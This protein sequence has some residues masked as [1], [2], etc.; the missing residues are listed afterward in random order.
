MLLREGYIMKTCRAAAFWY[1]LLIKQS[2]Y[3]PILDVSSCSGNDS[4]PTVNTLDRF[5]PSTPCGPHVE[6]RC[7]QKTH[8]SITKEAWQ[9]VTLWK[10]TLH[11]WIC[12]NWY[13]R[14]INTRIYL[15]LYPSAQPV[16]CMT[17]PPHMNVY[18][19]GQTKTWGWC[20]VSVTLLRK[21]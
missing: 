9:F 14:L 20:S 13:Y 17:F 4:S 1:S 5:L 16:T 6:C 10:V 8:I 12:V 19:S 15:V 18:I 3:R 2:V 11:H 7:K 21:S